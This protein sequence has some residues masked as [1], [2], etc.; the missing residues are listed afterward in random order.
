MGPVP[1]VD[2]TLHPF[3]AFL[4]ALRDDPVGADPER[5]TV[6]LVVLV[7]DAR[8]AI[9]P[10]HRDNP[11]LLVR[12]RIDLPGKRVEAVLIRHHQQRHHLLIAGG[13]AVAL[14]EGG[15]LQRFEQGV[16]IHTKALR[17]ALG[18]SGRIHS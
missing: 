2:D 9:D 10:N 16:G 3:R 6:E 7:D 15:R 1:A 12:E 18:Q 4:A 14:F 13:R 11:G 8:P 17:E 5:H